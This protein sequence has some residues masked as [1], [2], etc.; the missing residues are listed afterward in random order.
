MDLFAVASQPTEMSFS[1]RCEA[2]GIE[3]NGAS[4]NKSFAQRRNLLRPSF[5]RMLLDILRFYREAPRLLADETSPG[6][7]LGEY[8]E[9]NR[10]SAEFINRHIMPLGA[11]VCQPIRA[12]CSIFQRRCFCASFTITACCR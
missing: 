2:T 10:Y 3:Y 1:V 6:P 5:H 7:S 4:L 12:R 8:L 9:T 11:A